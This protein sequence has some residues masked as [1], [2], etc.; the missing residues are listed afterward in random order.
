MFHV[1]NV[2][3]V[4]KILEQLMIKNSLLLLRNPLLLY[5]VDGQ[6]K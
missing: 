2:K 4:Q 5:Y 1:I 3:T 6:F